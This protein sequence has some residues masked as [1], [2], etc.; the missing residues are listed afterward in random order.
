MS[1]PIKFIVQFICYCFYPFSFLFP[2]NKQ[3]WTFGS[4]RGAFND[5]AKYLFIETQRSHPEIQSAWISYNK[6]TVERLRAMKLT[7]YYL[8][9]FKG[10]FHALTSKYWVYNAYT[11]D[12]LFCLSGRA[13][14]VNLWHGVPIK[15]IEFDITEGPLAD[16]YVKKTLYYRYFYPQVYKRPNYIFAPSEFYREYFSKAFRIDKKQCVLSGCSRNNIL[17][18]NEEEREQFI[19]QFESKQTKLLLKTIEKYDKVFIYMP[20]WRDSQKDF[21]TTNFDLQR[22]DAAMA[23]INGLFLV[24]PHANTVIDTHLFV[25]CTHIQIIEPTSDVYPILPYTDVL[26]TDYSSIMY[27]Y[28]L[29]KDKDIILYLYDYEEYT[30]ERSFIFSFEENTIGARAFTFEDLCMYMKEAKQHFSCEDRNRIISKLWS[31]NA[32]ILNLNREIEQIK[33]L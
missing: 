15:S 21:F 10:F 27:D 4:F 3:K 32:S 9:T 29:M 25:Q 16:M 30:S 12:I 19:E 14:T 13:T 5:N 33:S 18:C 6:K 28:M 7:A 8:F 1:K 31:N 24:K 17:T 2:R 20:T 26:V 22:L 23:E 11:S